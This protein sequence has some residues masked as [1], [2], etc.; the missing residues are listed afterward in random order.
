MQPLRTSIWLH[1]SNQTASGKPGT[2]EVS[3]VK[4]FR[5]WRWHLDEVYVK[6]NSEMHYLWREVGRDQ[7]GVLHTAKRLPTG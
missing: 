1:D 4:G 3:R 7:I 6:I 5:H 2:L